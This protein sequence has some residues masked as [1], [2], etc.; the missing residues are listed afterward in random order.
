MNEPNF[1]VE[2]TA[3]R[4]AQEQGISY[5][6]ALAQAQRPLTRAEVDKMIEDM[7]KEHL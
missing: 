7:K 3:A 5:A 6:E 1:E 2:E 4:L